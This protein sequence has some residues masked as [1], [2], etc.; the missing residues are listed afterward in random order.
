MSAVVV[1]VLN[2]KGGAGKTSLT[3]DLG[4]ALADAGV[5]VLQV[6]LDPQSSLEVLAGLGFDTPPDR[7]VSRLLVPEEF[8]DPGQLE[9]VVHET[10]W[11][12]WLIPA[13][14]A[15]ASAERAL[16]EPGRGGPSQ[17]LKRGL[18]RLA[19]GERFDVVLIDCPPGMTPLTM[20][21]LVAADRVLVPTQLD[22][23]S[24]A[25]LAV[26]TETVE[27][28]REYENPQL[29]YLGIVGCQVEGR[30]RHARE[31]HAQLE[32]L[33]GRTAGGALCR[34]TIRHS[35]RVRDAHAAGLAVGQLDPGHPVSADYRA[36][37]A[38]LAD[39]AGLELGAEVA[40]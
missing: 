30:T 34:A 32:Q 26:L 11:G 37:A 35:T 9:R 27:E 18:Q 6:G 29:G 15:L 19:A 28:V 40:R 38:E 5:R 20:N 24:V 39:R 7:T 17:R 23:L 8:G 16:G 4:F 1:A 14:K 12:T 21:A 10:R 22:F 2:R 33:F 36:L 31:I 13:S 3:K 25:G